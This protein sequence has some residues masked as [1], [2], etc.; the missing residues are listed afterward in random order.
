LNFR[1]KMMISPAAI[2]QIT[3]FKFKIFILLFAS[4]ISSFFL[5]LLL[6]SLWIKHFFIQIKCTNFVI[7]IFQSRIRSFCP[8]TF[9]KLLSVKDKLIH[10]LFILVNFPQIELI[11]M[12]YWDS[13]L[14]KL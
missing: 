9:F 11:F 3:D 8:L 10:Q 1:R 14:F 12:K 6:H 4:F 13:C 2:S 5:N 7:D